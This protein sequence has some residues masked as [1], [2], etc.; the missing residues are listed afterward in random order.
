MAN[1]SLPSFVELMA[2][3]GLQDEHAANALLRG[4]APPDPGTTPPLPLVNT[5]DSS[6]YRQS[7]ASLDSTPTPLSTASSLVTPLSSPPV[8]RERPTSHGK[9]RY[10][11]YG[12]STLSGDVSTQFRPFIPIFLLCT[13]AHPP[14][15]RQTRLCPRRSLAGPPR[16]GQEAPSS[17]SPGTIS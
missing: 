4:A 6:T 13:Y 12:L 17:L 14:D 11:P 3:L 16:P 9:K 8:Q 7:I 1:P 10:S 2:S 5:P 15:L